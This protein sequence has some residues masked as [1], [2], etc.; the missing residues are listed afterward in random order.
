MNFGQLLILIAIFLM[1]AAMNTNFEKLTDA[2][3]MGCAG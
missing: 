1:L 3:A 2:I